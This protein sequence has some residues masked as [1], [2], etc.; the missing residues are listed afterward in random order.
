[1]SDVKYKSAIAAGIIA[2]S[3]VGIVTGLLIAPKSGK[4]MREDIAD[5]TK[6]GLDATKDKLGDIKDTA[7]DK[8]PTGGKDSALKASIKAAHE[9]LDKIG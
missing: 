9:A 4:E 2:G 3:A 6:E 5:K 8:L 1:M 7:K